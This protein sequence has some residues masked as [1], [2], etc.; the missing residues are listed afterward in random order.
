M[1]EAL[2]IVYKTMMRLKKHVGS[3]YGFSLIQFRFLLDLSIRQ[4]KALVSIVWLHLFLNNKGT[5][6]AE[7]DSTQSD[8]KASA[9]PAWWPSEAF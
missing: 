7:H 5:R 9:F 4:S 6:A 1:L 2:T 3:V 8:L